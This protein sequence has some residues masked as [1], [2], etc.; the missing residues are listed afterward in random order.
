[1]NTEAYSHA[2][3][4]EDKDTTRLF[5]QSEAHVVVRALLVRSSLLLLGGSGSHRSSLLGRCS[6]SGGGK[7]IWVG[8]VLLSLR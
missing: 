8:Q 3:H 1:M 2:E 5:K 6:R 7:G 4:I